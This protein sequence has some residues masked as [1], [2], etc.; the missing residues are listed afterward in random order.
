MIRLKLYGR[1]YCGLCVVMR[2]AL[3]QQAQGFELEWIDI[4][5]IEPLEEKYGEW[6]PVLEG[7]DG[8]EICHYHLDH[9]ALDAYLANFR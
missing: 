6:V 2:E 1:E 5:D 3:Q 7:A 4:D 8:V 9:A